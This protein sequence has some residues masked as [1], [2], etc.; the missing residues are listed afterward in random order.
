VKQKTVL[1]YIF[2]MAELDLHGVTH[3]EADRKVENFVFANQHNFPITIITGHSPDMKKIVRT[4]LD[5]N[6]FKH[7]DGD[8]SQSNMGVI[9]V[10]GFKTKK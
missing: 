2:N 8:Y 7:Y 5:R 4:V 1:S 6:K 3:A 10:E 9:T